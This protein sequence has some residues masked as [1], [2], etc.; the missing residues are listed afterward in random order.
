[1]DYTKKYQELQTKITKLK[2]DRVRLETTLGS[3]ENE[4]ETL[5]T[6]IL[7]KTKTNTLEEAKTKVDLIEAKLA[8]LYSEIE[9]VLKEVEDYEQ[10]S[11]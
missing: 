3:I 5:V 8:G 4:K 6:S 10:S 2:E 9:K 1:M 7:E 11:K